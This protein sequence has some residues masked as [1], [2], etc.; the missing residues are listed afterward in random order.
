MHRTAHQLSAICSHFQFEGELQGFRPFGNGHINDTYQITTNDHQNTY[1]YILQRL[2]PA[3]F[4]N[5]IKVMENVQRISEHIQKR[6]C[7]QKIPDLE[8]Q[9]IHWIKTREGLIYHL[10]AVDQCWR[11]YQYIDNAI[12][13]EQIFSTNQAQEIGKAYGRFLHLLDD[14]PAC[15]LHQTIPDFH[16]GPSK[17]QDFERALLASS[18]DRKDNAAKEILFLENQSKNIRLLAPKI[19]CGEI[20]TRVTHNDTKINNVLI[21][22]YTDKGLAVIDLDTVMPGCVLFDFGDMVRTCATYST[23]D[24]RD[25]SKVTLDLSLFEALT[26]GYLQQ[27]KRTL[28]TVEIELLPFAGQYMAL[29]IGCRFLTDYLQGDIYFKTHHPEQNLDRCRTQFKLAQ[30]MI[31][32]T[33]ALTAI[34]EKYR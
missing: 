27:T 12:A 29:L 33:D 31:E 10:D 4:P 24:E 23:E 34:V 18:D 7:V 20:P 30:S 17:F 2:N 25:L 9:Y 22:E 6:L 1:T 32:Q 28:T 8:R 19:R 13:S 11:E 5:S 16:D 3:I 21:D 14:F 26:Y 15:L